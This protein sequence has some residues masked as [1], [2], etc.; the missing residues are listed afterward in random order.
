M[1]FV[2]MLRCR[3]GS[4][5]VG[6]TQDVETRLRVHQSGKGPA[7]TAKRLPVELVYQEPFATLEEVVQREQQLKGW[8]RAKKEALVAGDKQKLQDLPTSR[9][10]K[11]IR[12]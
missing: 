1:H 9:Q 4:Y 8:T 11:H 7:F 3:D 6:S 5:Y 10:T 2:Y 12:R